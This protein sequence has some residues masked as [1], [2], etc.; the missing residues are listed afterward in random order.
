MRFAAGGMRDQVPLD[1]RRALIFQA[2]ADVFRR[3]RV[4]QLLVGERQLLE[5][6]R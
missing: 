4:A 5:R 1:G 3:N 6:E 2:R